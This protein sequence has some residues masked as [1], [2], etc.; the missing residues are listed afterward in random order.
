MNKMFFALLSVLIAFGVN[1]QPAEVIKMKLSHY[2]AVDHPGGVAAKQFADN[3]KTRT[4]GGILIE[5]Y[6]N[7]ELGSPDEML[8]Q[9]ILGVVDMTLGTQGSLDKYSK[10]FAVVMLPFVFKDY[11][12]AYR[13]LDGAFYDWTKD[14]LLSQGLVFIGSWDYGFR[15]LTNSVRPVNSPDDVKGLKIRTP[16]EIQ[17]QSCITALGANVQAI[18]F[19]ELYLSLRQGMVDGQEN[20]LSVIWFNKYYEAQKYL[21]ITKHVY[22]SMNL[23]V[24]KKVWD[25]LSP[26]YRSIITEESKK[27]AETMRI[28]TKNGDEDYIAK[29]EKAGMTV[30][31]PDIEQFSKLMKPSY[32][33]ITKYVG[34]PEYVSTFLK[35]V[36]AAK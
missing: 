7:N 33:A 20:P 10:K 2:A 6:P 31:R 24:S 35:M 18:P 25:K 17:L 12:H 23:V 26:E 34:N 8:E 19:A 5:V 11:D 36:D 4:N 27:A 9:N 22:N 15:N 29:L 3:V 30:T 14:E 13:V 21:A 28:T 32:D 1:A 16:G